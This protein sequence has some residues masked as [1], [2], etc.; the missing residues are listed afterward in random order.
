VH[1][2]NLKSSL[3][4][5]QMLVVS[6]LEDL[7][8][9]LPEDLLVNLSESMDVVLSLLDSL[10]T[11]FQNTKNV[12]SCFG[13]AIDGAFRVMGH[14][15]GKMCVFQTNL[16]VLGPGQLKPRENNKLL[17]T[18]TE[19][20]LFAPSSVYYE[21]KAAEFARQQIAVDLF[22]FSPQYT[23]V[24]TLGSL[25]KLT[26]GQLHYYPGFT[27][28]VSSEKF[29]KELS[30]CL[31]RTTGF[32]GVMRVRCTKGM[33]PKKMYG[34]YITRGRDLLGLPNCSSDSALTVEFAHDEEM[35]SSPVIY[36]QAA[37]LYTT[38]SFSRRIRVHTV[39][40][41]VTTV[42]IDC[43]QFADV[44]TAC[45]ILSKHAI[46]IAKRSGL[47]SARK[48]LQGKCIDTIQSYKNA[49]MSQ[50]ASSQQNPNDPND[51]LPSNLQLLPLYIM[52]LQKNITF[53]GGVDIRPD[54]RM[55]MIHQLNGMSVNQSR[56]FVYPNL[57]ALHSMT[58]EC[59]KP[60][61]I[62]KDEAAVH[63]AGKRN[64]LL[65][66]T[67]KLRAE[68]L[69]SNGI[70]LLED[71][72]SMYIWIGKSAPS[73]L[74]QMLFGAPHENID[75]TQ[76]SLQ[77]LGTNFS[78]RVNNIVNA[79]REERSSFPRLIFL[80][81]GD[82]AEARFF[83]HLVEERANF[84]DCRQSYAEYLSMVTRKSGAPTHGKNKGGKGATPYHSG[85]APTSLQ[86]PRGMVGATPG[87]GVAVGA[88]GPPAVRQVHGVAPPPQMQKGARGMP[89]S[90][91][92]HFG[93]PTGTKGLKGK[94]GMPRPPQMPGSAQIRPP[95]QQFGGPPPGGVP[96]SHYNH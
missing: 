52:S 18:E 94:G 8:L 13:A 45:N 65:P 58:S 61:E 56:V 50:P 80:K 19:H 25:T 48:Y 86:A 70:Y 47:S 93:G 42:S 34:N 63:V 39:A 77:D 83:M 26:G 62:S 22:L 89:P 28:Q 11:M 43:Y 91:S 9:P 16:P 17:G 24:A 79:I 84:A 33:A 46:E 68:V 20:N 35:L 76:L 2:Y 78:S 73:E 81:E 72:V 64:I 6:E 53:R 5:P 40:V 21:N 88:R 49:V 95:P 44:D 96:P 41:P 31:T 14:I 15:G 71:S 54:E 7:F 87:K 90:M 82:H 29:S 37:L 10:P 38:S 85:G 27:A 57:Y 32:E 55:F 4:A 23:D 12:E 92:N 30:H 74:L 59:G 75:C 66:P 51:F 1:F 60:I 3:N 67:Q 36:I 69:E